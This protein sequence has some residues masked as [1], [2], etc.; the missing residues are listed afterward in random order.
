MQDWE[1]VDEDEFRRLSASVRGRCKLKAVNN[2]YALIRTH[3]LPF[4]ANNI[5]AAAAASGSAEG[6]GGGRRKKR[7]KKA[8]PL[9]I[10]MLNKQGGKVST[11]R[12]HVIVMHIEHQRAHTTTD[13]CPSL[14]C[15]S[16]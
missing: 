1:V 5:K 11:T 13:M 9:T 4:L 3:F 12:M 16:E 7:L 8:A 6:G 2:V 14:I 10:P 15:L